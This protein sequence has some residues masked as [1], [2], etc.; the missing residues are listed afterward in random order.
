MVKID[1]LEK[2]DLV[3]IALSADAKRAL[4]SYWFY[5]SDK[6][7]ETNVPGRFHVGYLSKLEEDGVFLAQD[8]N[9]PKN[10]PERGATNFGF[11]V[12]ESYRKL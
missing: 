6:S 2:G 4:D 5:F 9:K 7:G 11:D 1:G 10:R 8:W 12:V 3:E